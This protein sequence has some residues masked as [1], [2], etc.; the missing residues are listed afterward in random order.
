MFVG[1]DLGGSKI[2]YAV[3]DHVQGRVLA[4]RVSPTG[5]ADGPDAVLMRMADD[6]R[7][8]VVD[9]GIALSDVRGIGCGVPGVY[10]DATGHTLF[11][12]NLI[13]T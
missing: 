9:A 13:G 1:V 11:L 7:R 12:P 6:I 3:I 4:R 8:V 5:S 2:A 10:D